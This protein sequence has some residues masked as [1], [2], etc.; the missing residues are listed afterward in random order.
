M[1][2]SRSGKLDDEMTELGFWRP[3]HLL[4]VG[5]SHRSSS[6]LTSAV[7]SPELEIKPSNASVHDQ[8][9]LVLL[10]TAKYGDCK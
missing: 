6:C 5:T 10:N 2:D 3:G 7:R 9:A 1:A 4:E 8:S